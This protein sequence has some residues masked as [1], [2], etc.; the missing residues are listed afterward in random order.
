[1][2][3]SNNKYNIDVFFTFETTASPS[4]EPRRPICVELAKRLPP[5][6]QLLKK[7]M[8]WSNN[9]T[10]CK[11][12]Q[13]DLSRSRSFCFSPESS[14]KLE[15]VWPLQSPNFNYSIW[16]NTE[17][18]KFFGLNYINPGQ[19]FAKAVKPNYLIWCLH[20][21]HTLNINT[22]FIHII[23]RVAVQLHKYKESTGS[24]G[25]YP[26]WNIEEKMC[27]QVNLYFQKYIICNT[28]IKLT[29]ICYKLCIN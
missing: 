6:R 24:Q 21:A 12:R 10:R 27:Y 28:N 23:H 25:L 19:T 7:V 18:W 26:V 17:Q 14:W 4:E 16:K 20:R 11:T 3:W 22:V 13:Q 5:L 2:P 1:M 8:W 29:C 9:K 15:E